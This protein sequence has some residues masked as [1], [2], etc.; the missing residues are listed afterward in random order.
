MAYLKSLIFSK[1]RKKQSYSNTR[2]ETNLWSGQLLKSG[3]LHTLIHPWIIDIV[4]GD[5]FDPKSTQFNNPES[6]IVEFVIN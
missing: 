5:S 4:R 1:R 6:I 2:D 3:S